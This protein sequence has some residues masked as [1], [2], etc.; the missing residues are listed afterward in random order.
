M[1]NKQK[2]NKMGK[3]DSYQS[4]APEFQKLEKGDHD[5][6]LV[7][8]KTIDS[9]HNYDG[10]LKPNLPAYTNPTEQLVITVVSANGKGGLTHRLNMDGYVRFSELTE[11]EVKSGKFV[12]IDSYACAKD[13]KTGDLVRI[14]DEA[15]T[16]TCEGILDQ[17]FAAMQIPVGSGLDALDE[18][19]QN[20]VVF[21]INVTSEKYEDKDQLRIG[22][23]RKAK[24]SAPATQKSALEA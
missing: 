9:F 3:L 14:T 11:K 21:N 16:K 22:S 2:Q 13:P 18:A 15:R 5:V 6:R 8:Y 12:E 7:S 4:K 17:M 24:T 23:F 1:S 10:T 20:K 19:I